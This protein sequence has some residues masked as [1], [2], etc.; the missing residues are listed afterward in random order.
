MKSKKK[1]FFLNDSTTSILRHS[2]CLASGIIAFDIGVRVIRFF[3][4]QQT[5]KLLN[6]PS[7]SRVMGALHSLKPPFL[8]TKYTQHHPQSKVH[9]SLLR[10]EHPYLTQPENAPHLP[11]KI[12]RTKKR[13]SDDWRERPD[14]EG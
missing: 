1:P 14:L 7:F 8:T 6:R 4:A 10:S 13:R 12:G 3:F 2:V 11:K 9:L 5:C